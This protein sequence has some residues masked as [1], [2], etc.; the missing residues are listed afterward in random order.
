VSVT[1]PLPPPRRL[2]PA[3]SA[4][5]IAAAEVREEKKNAPVPPPVPKTPEQL[6][7]AR[8]LAIYAEAAKRYDFTMRIITFLMITMMT[9]IIKT[10]L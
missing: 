3:P 1:T 2:N 9:M 5:A 8:M 7:K 4:D 6:E 10:K